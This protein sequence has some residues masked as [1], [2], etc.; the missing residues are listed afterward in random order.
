MKMKII[1]KNNININ[2]FSVGEGTSGRSRPEAV[3]NDLVHVCDMHVEREESC[4][5]VDC[6]SSERGRRNATQ[7]QDAHTLRDIHHAH[8]FQQHDVHGLGL[9]RPR[10]QQQGVFTQLHPACGVQCLKNRGNSRIVRIDFGN[11]VSVADHFIVGALVLLR[12]QRQVLD[13]VAYAVLVKC[14]T[15][16][17]LV[18]DVVIQVKTETA[19][20]VLDVGIHLFDFV[21]EILDTEMRV[22]DGIHRK[23][24]LADDKSTIQYTAAAAG[25]KMNK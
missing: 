13:Q 19:F 21:A 5:I 23:G 9:A 3:G 10:I 6:V 17:V 8:V 25:S 7:I 14:R 1:K 2:I 11:H 18:D 15:G 16:C 12:S 20:V 4:R 22:L 24:I